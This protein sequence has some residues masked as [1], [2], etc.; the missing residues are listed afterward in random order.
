MKFTFSVTLFTFAAIA[1]AAPIP[2]ETSD[3]IPAG[4]LPLRP[5]DMDGNIDVPVSEAGVRAAAVGF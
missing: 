1:W 3:S 4:V 5:G 2:G